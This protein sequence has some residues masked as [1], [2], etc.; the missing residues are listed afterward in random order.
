MLR[1]GIIGKGYFGKKLY[2]KLNNFTK[3]VFFTGR[4]LDINYEVDWV[5]IASSTDSHYE[6]CKIFL[7]KGINVF[8]E[9][10]MTLSYKHSKELVKLSK[11]VGVR[12]YVDDV[13][14]WHPTTKD[15][16]NS[17]ITN[18]EFYWN[19][20]GSFTDN[21]FN[22]L[23]Y[24]DLYL[25]LHLGK[26]LEGKIKIE[27]NRV[28][29]KCFWIGDVK[30]CYNRISKNKQKYLL[31][32]GTSYDYSTT[33]DPLKEMLQDVLFEKVDF[34]QNLTTSLKVHKILDKLNNH[35]PKVAVVGAGIFGISSALSLKDLDVTLYERNNDILSEASSTNQ[36][37]LHRG[38]HYPRSID[39]AISSNK[40]TQTFVEDYPC[41][42][43]NT[44]QYYAI[45]SRNSKVSSQ[46]YESFMDEVSL[47]Y[48]IV[49][50]N[51]VNE[52]N[53]DKVY[54]A[55]ETLFDPCKL[56]E[57]CKDK[58]NKSNINL[59]LNTEFTQDI[60]DSYDYVINCTYSNLNQINNDKQLYQFEV[61]EKPLLKLPK[62][63]KD[64]GIVI[65]DGPFMC[66][67]PYSNTD[68][69]VMGNV[70]HAIHETNTGTHPIVSDELKSV[71]N[72]G[73]VKNPKITNIDKFIESASEF[74]DMEG[75]EHIGSMFTIRTVL[76]N[77]DHDDARPS[78][79]KK[80]NQKLY[81]IFSGKISTTVDT[82]KELE[83]YIMN[84]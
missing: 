14:L 53:I 18:L 13:F 23:A 61:C 50:S 59:K 22:S 2:E 68:Y 51:L 26:S 66:I 58:L 11:K 10:P 20:Y 83:K 70:V 49:K 6:L 30:F 37:R 28:N 62:K 55:N 63:Y 65:M 47:D 80:H 67:D 36:Y 76:A 1:V 44:K 4:E 48:T 56:Y 5:I 74:F 46:E 64:I 81:S 41:E 33:K 34:E 16:K 7:S 8:V 9:K 79:V 31:V 82:S 15:L 42:I 72:K 69:H 35:K 78:I 45:A 71:L 75:V 43:S 27:L 38:Y 19:K 21:V 73:L 52:L 77:R 3:V 39:T 12:F 17:Q 60:V 25:A 29:E 54:L 40:G 32:N 24:H 84:S 57:I